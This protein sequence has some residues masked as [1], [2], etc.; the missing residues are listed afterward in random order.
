MFILCIIDRTG[1]PWT[2]AKSPWNTAAWNDE[3][4]C[5]IMKNINENVMKK[6]NEINT[7]VKKYE[8]IFHHTK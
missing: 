6:H 5:E 8:V 2:D 3:N 1:H 7:D 4:G